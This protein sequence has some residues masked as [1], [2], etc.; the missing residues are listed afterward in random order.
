SCTWF[1]C[2]ADINPGRKKQNRSFRIYRETLSRFSCAASELIVNIFY[3]LNLELTV[4]QIKVYL[5]CSFFKER[6]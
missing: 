5:I 6:V 3:K 1:G 2:A 4:F